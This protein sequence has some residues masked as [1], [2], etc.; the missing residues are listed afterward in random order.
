MWIID[1]IIYFTRYEDR[2]S[3]GVV[4]NVLH[5]REKNVCIIVESLKYLFIY[6]KNKI[7]TQ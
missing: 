2:G 4:V 3:N 7:Y 1:S 6:V 5:Y